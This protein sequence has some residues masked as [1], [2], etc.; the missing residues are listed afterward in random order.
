M[1]RQSRGRARRGVLGA[2]S[3]LLS[4]AWTKI[5]DHAWVCRTNRPFDS[6]MIQPRCSPFMQPV[7]SKIAPDYHLVV[8]QPMDLG[9][10]REVLVF[11]TTHSNLP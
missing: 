4:K 2:L 3:Q 9:T 1:P 7:T 6:D 11:N 8:K 5:T 10:I